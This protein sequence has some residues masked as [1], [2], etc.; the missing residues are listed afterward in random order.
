MMQGS[1]LRSLLCSWAR[2]SARNGGAEDQPTERRRRGLRANP[3]ICAR[4]GMGSFTH[5]AAT[6]GPPPCSDELV[7]IGIR[8]RG[9]A[10]R[11]VDLGEDVAD[12]PINRLLA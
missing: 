9:G 10:A 7:L 6:N 3:P 12:V 4:D 11:D 5:A 1:R 2:S 8:R